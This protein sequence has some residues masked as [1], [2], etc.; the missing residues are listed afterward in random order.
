MLDQLFS[1]AGNTLGANLINLGWQNYQTQGNQQW[2]EEKE[3]RDYARST[4][5]IQDR[6]QDA[7]KAGVHPLYALGGGGFS[8]SQAVSLSD[9][10]TPFNSMGQDLS[11]AAKAG[12][13]AEERQ[14]H[15]LR[16]QLLQGQVE[17]Q[18]LINMGMWDKL[19][20]TDQ[21]APAASSG[22]AVSYPVTGGTPPTETAL[23]ADAV[24]P[25]PIERTTTRSGDD[26]TTAGRHAHW[27][28]FDM[29]H[30]GD[31]KRVRILLPTSKGDPAE[32]W[33]SIGE[34]FLLAYQTIKANVQKYGWAWLDD[35][36]GVPLT[37]SVK[38]ALRAFRAGNA[39]REQMRQ[40]DQNMS[41][42]YGVPRYSG[43]RYTP[44]PKAPGLSQ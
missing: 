29:V 42:P 2:N 5:Y 37:K 8:G 32:A 6:V 19:M 28:E 13:S 20:N 36:S 10:S 34:S 35:V 25:T 4:R 33:E 12:M 38:D 41:H 17:H 26:S 3:K 9:S 11:R 15:E 43:P 30:Q 16:V 1:A 39:R 22:G 7:I 44:A 14:L 18:D 27:T 21:L 23:M 31:G 40:F 24:K